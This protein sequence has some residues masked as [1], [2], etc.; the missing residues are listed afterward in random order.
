MKISYENQTKENYIY[1][2]MHK[3]YLENEIGFMI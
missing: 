3:P 1:Y 2:N